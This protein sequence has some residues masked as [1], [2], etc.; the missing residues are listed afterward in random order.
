MTSVGAGEQQGGS[1]TIA[2]LLVLFGP[3]PPIRVVIDCQIAG[4]RRQIFNRPF[5][6]LRE[7]VYGARGVNPINNNKRPR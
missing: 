4:R 6:L 2:S 5:D 7:Y 3:V 1:I